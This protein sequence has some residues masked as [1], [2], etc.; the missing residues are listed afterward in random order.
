MPF[1]L[2]GAGKIYVGLASTGLENSTF[3][4]Y[5]GRIAHSIDKKFIRTLGLCILPFTR[6]L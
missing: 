5:L 4:R 3:P 6:Y 2:Y 1:A